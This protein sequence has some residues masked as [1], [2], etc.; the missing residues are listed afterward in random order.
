MFW[1][2]VQVSGKGGK[3]RTVEIPDVDEVDENGR[4]LCTVQQWIWGFE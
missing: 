4:Q 1:R 3:E 2:D